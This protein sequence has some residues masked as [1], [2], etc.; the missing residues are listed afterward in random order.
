MPYHV[1]FVRLAALNVEKAAE[2]ALEAEAVLQYQLPEP[3]EYFVLEERVNETVAAAALA[4]HDY[5]EDPV[6]AAERAAFE[7]FEMVDPEI[8]LVE[9]HEQIQDLRPA[10]LDLIKPMFVYPEEEAAWRRGIFDTAA[11]QLLYREDA[12]VTERPWTREECP[13]AAQWLDQYSNHLDELGKVLPNFTHFYVPIVAVSGSRTIVATSL[14]GVS[15]LRKLSQSYQIRALYH[16]Q[17]QSTKAAI[18]DFIVQMQLSTYCQRSPLLVE[19]LIAYS[20]HRMATETL[21]DILLSSSLTESDLQ[22]L[23]LILDQPRTFNQPSQC[24]DQGERIMTVDCVVQIVVNDEKGFLDDTYWDRTI[25]CWDDVLRELNHQYD[26]FS[27]AAKSG[28]YQALQKL[29]QQITAH[30]QAAQY[31]EW[32]KQRPWYLLPSQRTEVVKYVYAQTFLPPLAATFQANLRAKIRNDLA[33]T[34]VPSNVS[35]VRRKP[36]PRRSRN[37]CRNTCPR[38]PT[39]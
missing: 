16:L 8:G 30:P 14:P 17:K 31:K 10:A 20:L 18:Q 28:N 13:L 23:A 7:T 38:C 12:I 24:I 5:A 6:A 25:V 9:D 1:R 22:E 11:N 27:A 21:R 4:I 39:T 37:W 2:R 29:S 19:T 35:T 15:T 34:Y 36:I 32:Y 3:E 33:R 26:M